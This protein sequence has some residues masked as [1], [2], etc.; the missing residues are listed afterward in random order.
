M[1]LSDSTVA[2][3]SRTDLNTNLT[4]LIYF[5]AKNT[6]KKI[7]AILQRIFLS[8]EAR[9]YSLQAKSFSTGAWHLRMPKRGVVCH[10]FTL[11]CHIHARASRFRVPCFCCPSRLAVNHCLPIYL[12]F[13]SLQSQPGYFRSL[14]GI[15]GKLVYQIFACECLSNRSSLR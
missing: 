11:L 4:S 15:Y 6:F 5:S 3:K 12:R 1:F 10:L 9:E 13:V 7:F 14:F 8:P 2:R